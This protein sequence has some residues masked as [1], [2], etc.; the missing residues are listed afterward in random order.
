VEGS[1][2]FVRELNGLSSWDWNKPSAP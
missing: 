1:S 2:L